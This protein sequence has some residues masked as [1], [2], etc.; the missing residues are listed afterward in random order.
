LRCHFD[1][2]CCHKCNLSVGW[3]VYSTT[4]EKKVK[5][6]V[7]CS[8]KHKHHHGWCCNSCVE[9][10]ASQEGSVAEEEKK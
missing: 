2:L 6:K 7:K 1:R 3:G 9:R 5:T 8:R 4:G 10:N